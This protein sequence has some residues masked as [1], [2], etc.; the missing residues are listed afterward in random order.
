[1]IIAAWIV[2]GIVLAYLF[3]TCFAVTDPFDWCD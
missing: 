1:M 3:Y 2:V